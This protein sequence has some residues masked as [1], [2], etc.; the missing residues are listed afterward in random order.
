MLARNTKQHTDWHGE[1]P[2]QTLREGISFPPKGRQYLQCIE[3]NIDLNAEGR[4]TWGPRSTGNVMRSN[5]WEGISFPQESQQLPNKSQ[6][7]SQQIPTRVTTNPHKGPPYS[8]IHICV[9]WGFR[10]ILVEVSLEFVLFCWDPGP[11]IW[12]EK[13]FL[14][15]AA[16]SRPCSH[17]TLDWQHWNSWCAMIY[18]YIYIYIYISDLRDRQHKIKHNNYKHIV[19]SYIS[20]SFCVCSPT[21]R[22]MSRL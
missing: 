20:C 13:P 4:K 9:F 18:I 5:L 3:K 1:H 11:G 12:A 16:F 17:P 21:F 10:W 19:W 15:D 8:D 22:P 14:R 2:S 6:Q 7:E